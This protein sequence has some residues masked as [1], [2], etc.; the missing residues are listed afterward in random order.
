[1]KIDIFDKIH[2]WFYGNIAKKKEKAGKGKYDTIPQALPALIRAQKVLKTAGE[3]K[4]EVQNPKDSKT[5][6]D[7]LFNLVR[8]MRNEGID[9]EEALSDAI[10][11]F[12][13]EDKNSD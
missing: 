13:A 6:G 10:T 9:G 12:I 7:E 3:K 8:Q 5:W 4:T 11:R 1:M 2:S